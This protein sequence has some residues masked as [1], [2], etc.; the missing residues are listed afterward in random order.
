MPIELWTKAALQKNT[1]IGAKVATPKPVVL[2]IW[3]YKC[4]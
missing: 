1:F 4:I 3:K 2:A